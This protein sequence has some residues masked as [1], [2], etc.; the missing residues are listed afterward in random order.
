MIADILGDDLDF[1]DEMNDDSELEEPEGNTSQQ[2]ETSTNDEDEISVAT[3]DLEKDVANDLAGMNIEDIG[4]EVT[5]EHLDILTKSL[6]G[7]EDIENKL[8]NVDE[9]DLGD[10]ERRNIDAEER[11]YQLED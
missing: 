3:S 2:L 5:E 1:V 7:G 8:D 6:S 11:V 10:F 4:S 9:L